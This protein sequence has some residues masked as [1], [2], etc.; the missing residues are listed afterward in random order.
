MGIQEWLTKMWHKTISVGT[1]THNCSNCIYSEEEGT[2]YICRARQS[3]VSEN[4]FCIKH[5]YRE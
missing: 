3:A 2:G 1:V 5:T 4:G